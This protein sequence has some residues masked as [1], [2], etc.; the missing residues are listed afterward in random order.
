MAIIFTPAFCCSDL[1]PAAL[2]HYNGRIDQ[3]FFFIE[4]ASVARLIDNIG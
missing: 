2:G 1:C 4:R 3:A